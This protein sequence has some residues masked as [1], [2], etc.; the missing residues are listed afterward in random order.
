MLRLVSNDTDD[1]KHGATGT[2]AGAISDALAVPPTG[3]NGHARKL[4][5]ETGE[6]SDTT[7]DVDTDDEDD[8]QPATSSTS[9]PASQGPDA[10]PKKRGGRK[11]GSKNRISREVLA[12][13]R[14]LAPKRVLEVL[15]FQWRMATGRPVYRKLRGG[16][17]ELVTYGVQEM[18]AAG[19]AFN[20]SFIAKGLEIDVTTEIEAEEPASIRELSRALLAGVRIASAHNDE[21]GDDESGDE[22]ETPGGGS[23]TEPPSTPGD[24]WGPIE[25]H[26]HRPENFKKIPGDETSPLVAHLGSPSSGS[27]TPFYS[28]ESPRRE[29]GSAE[30]AVV[31]S[32]TLGGRPDMPSGW[33]L[34]PGERHGQAIINVIDAGGAIRGR[35]YTRSDA[36]ALAKRL[37]AADAEKEIIS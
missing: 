26:P 21:A 35:H 19:K 36:I 15:E 13:S 22:A 33:Q 14:D 23:T 5:G 6:P 25:P 32:Q 27:A 9:S 8:A 7:G 12:A 17:R 24:F 34:Q 11:L 28:G 1:E 3:S 29:K 10:L 30:G 20:G 18:L 37:A 31:A 16:G 4:T 2:V